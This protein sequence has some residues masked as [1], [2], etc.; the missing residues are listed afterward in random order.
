MLILFF[1][2]ILYTI[3]FAKTIHTIISE[4]VK[5]SNEPILYFSSATSFAFIVLISTGIAYLSSWNNLL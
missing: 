5:F 1:F 3:I 2:F 4:N